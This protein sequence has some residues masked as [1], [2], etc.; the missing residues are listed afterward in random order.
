MKSE[1]LVVQS[2]VGLAEMSQLAVMRRIDTYRKG[3]EKSVVTDKSLLHVLPADSE[4]RDFCG[5]LSKNPSRP[6]F[7]TPVTSIGNGLAAA[8]RTIEPDDI[9]SFVSP[10][11]N[12]V[13]SADMKEVAA[14]KGTYVLAFYEEKRGRYAQRKDIPVVIGFDCDWVSN[15]SVAAPLPDRIIVDSAVGH[16]SG[17]VVYIWDGKRWQ[18]QYQFLDQFVPTL[19][20][21]TFWTPL[22]LRLNGSRFSLQEIPYCCDGVS[23]KYPNKW[24]E[25]IFDLQT[26]QLIDVVLHDDVRR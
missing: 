3:V 8:V 14:K 23:P 10:W 4:K 12:D 25:F 19:K 17:P 11:E 6:Y 7:F 13:S 26:L 1:E 9:R 16:E 5:E 22:A 2:D 18:E 20:K 21:R 15:F 24:S